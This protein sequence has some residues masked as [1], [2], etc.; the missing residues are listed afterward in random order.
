MNSTRFGLPSVDHLL[1]RFRD[2]SRRPSGNNPGFLVYWGQRTENGE[3]GALSETARSKPAIIADD[4]I[5][6]CALIHLAGLSE[7][8]ERKRQKARVPNLMVLPGLKARQAEG[9][10]PN[11]YVDNQNC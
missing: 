8:K 1:Q 5:V 2:P 3:T 7:Q 4:R 11:G 9:S 6:A 10:R